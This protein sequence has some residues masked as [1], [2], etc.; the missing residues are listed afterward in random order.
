MYKYDNILPII[1][2]ASKTNSDIEEELYNNYYL[3]FYEI[4]YSKELINDDSILI[5]CNFKSDT[6]KKQLQVQGSVKS[7]KDILNDLNNSINNTDFVVDKI[8]TQNN[9]NY[10]LEINDKIKIKTTNVK[11]NFLDKLN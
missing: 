7:D 10:L 4:L 9:A 2:L 8:I 6:M 3:N 5:F 11:L 1:L